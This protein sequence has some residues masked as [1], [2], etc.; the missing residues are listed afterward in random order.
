M[1]SS[2]SFNGIPVLSISA[3]VLSSPIN[4]ATLPWNGL[5]KSYQWTLTLSITTQFQSGTTTR[6]KEQYNGMDVNVG[7]W[8]ASISSG[9]AWQIVSISSKSASSVTCVVQDIFRYNTY[10]DPARTG[11]GKPATGSYVVFTLAEDGSPL[12][13]PAPAGLGA[14]FL[15]TLTTRF[16][17]INLEQ[18]D[19]PLGKPGNAAITFNYG[20]IIA[21]DQPTGFFVLAD[22][23]HTNIVGR[24]TGVD[25]S[26]IYFAV[27]PI[28]K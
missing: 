11:N 14:N 6:Q 4:G 1:T 13:D 20:D 26:G 16:S 24:V 12:V 17:Y 9:L 23:T 8:I 25:D 22:S 10:R 2:T 18:Y 5:A 19:F 3:S 27:D 28:R 21:T 15:S 7:Q